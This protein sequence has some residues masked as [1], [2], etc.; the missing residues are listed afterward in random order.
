MEAAEKLKRARIQIQAD[1]PFFAYLSL[2]LKFREAKEGE[3]PAWGGMGVDARGNCWYRKDFVEKITDNELK[4][5]IVHEILHLSFLHLIREGRREHNKWNIAIDI[6][7]NYILEQNNFDLPNGCLVAEYD[8]SITVFGQKIENVNKK[9]PEQ[10]YDEFKFKLKTQKTFKVSGGS[11]RGE[12]KENPED[13]G[14]SYK[15]FDYH[16]YQEGKGG[17][18]LKEEERVELEREWKERLSEAYVTAQQIGKVP[19]EIE[20]LMGNIHKNELNWRNILLKNVQSVIPYDYTYAVPHKKSCSAGY[21]M[22]NTTKE[23]VNIAVGVDVSGSVGEKEYADFL[24][25]VIGMAQAFR[26]R[27]CIRFLTHDVKVQNDYVVENGN[28]EK[29][30][31]LKITGGG[32]TSH[33]PIMEYIKENVRNIKLAIFLTDGYSDLEEIPL[34][35]YNFKKIFVIQRNGNENCIRDKDYRNL[36]IKLKGDY[37]N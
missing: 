2:Y 36:V 24:S 31:A 25:E 37:N 15:G 34:N 10:I 23:M 28:V 16:D 19:A 5:V 8:K 9:T 12:G 3:L 22:P 18:K 1:N 4:G 26:G 33:K 27:I 17:G 32:G 6:V 13:D 20:R 7:V 11:K 29:I 35:E 14:D 21:Y 30:K